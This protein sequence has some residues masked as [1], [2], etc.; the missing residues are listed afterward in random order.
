MAITWGDV[1]PAGERNFLVARD[2]DMERNQPVQPGC[3]T[4]HEGGAHVLDE[5]D[6]NWKLCR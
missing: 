1:D 4:F 5:Q 6:G 2:S 3:E